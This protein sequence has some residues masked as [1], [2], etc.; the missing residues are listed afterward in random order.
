M[1]IYYGT[2]GRRIGSVGNETYAVSKGQNVVREK[3]AQVANPRTDAQMTQRSQFLSAIRF[4]QRANQRF[5]KFA[6]ESKKS[7]ESDYNAFMRHNAKIGGYITKAQGD[8]VGYPMVVPWIMSQ[9]SLEGVRQSIYEDVENERSYLAV[10]VA[11]NFTGDVPVTIGELSTLLKANYPSVQEGDILTLV[12][13]LATTSGSSYVNDFDAEDIT[14]E[15]R[16]FLEQFYVDVE[17]VR[18]ISE[19][20]LGGACV[21]RDGVL[22]LQ[23]EIGAS[24]NAAASV[25]VQSRNTDKGLK[26]STAVLVLNAAAE[27]VYDATRSNEHREQVLAWWGAQQAAILQGALAEVQQEPST[28]KPN[29]VS[30]D[31]DYNLPVNSGV[32]AGDNSDFELGFSSSPANV[33]SDDFRIVG[34]RA[35][36]WSIDYEAGA[37]QITV[38][39]EGDATGSVDLYYRN[40][41]I[42]H[43]T[44]L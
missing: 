23:N 17:D 44:I 30:V 33:V 38:T 27:F 37:T 18:L 11:T 21:I 15:N 36:K 4:F 25:M 16:W 5:F 12:S 32:T 35:S 6:F 22:Y 42:I 43:L 19:V 39:S 2:G 3:P 9:G 28:R 41:K 10:E 7:K 8:A 26:V 20:I 29:I 1:A 24:E 34:F 14:N 31:N 40:Q 13:I